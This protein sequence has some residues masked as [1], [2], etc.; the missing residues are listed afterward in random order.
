MEVSILKFKSKLTFSQ[1][2]KNIVSKYAKTT[3]R[4]LFNELRVPEPYIK[5][6]IWCSMNKY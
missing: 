2:Y 1:K 6:N 3:L 4:M 5:L